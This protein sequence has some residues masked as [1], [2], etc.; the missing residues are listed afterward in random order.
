MGEL[1]SVRGGGVAKE[2]LMIMGEPCTE[3]CE[4]EDQFCEQLLEGFL[5]A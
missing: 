4:A 2:G 5:S 3:T 1:M